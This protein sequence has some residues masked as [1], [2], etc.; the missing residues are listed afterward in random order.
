MSIEPTGS[1]VRARPAGAIWFIVLGV[2]WII[3][4]LAVLAEPWYA[5]FALVLV[6]GIFLLVG[7][8]IH[9]VQAFFTRG[10]RGF[11]FHLLEGLLCILVGILLIADPVRGAIGLTLLIGIF[12][13]VGGVVRC[14]LAVMVRGAPVWIWLLV[15]GLIEILLAFIILS[16]W[17]GSAAW[18][19]GLFIGIRMLFTGASMLALGVVPR[20]AAPAAPP[21]PI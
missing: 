9:T 4:G 16:N 13:L 19:I 8:I 11:L 6:A 17:P 15:D 18:V 7:G 10:W 12:L 20:G 3:L 5:T 21:A 1:E 14:V 2:I